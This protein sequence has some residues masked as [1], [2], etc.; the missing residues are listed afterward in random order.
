MRRSAIHRAVAM[1]WRTARRSALVDV[2]LALLET[3]NVTYSAMWKHVS[4]TEVTAASALRLAQRRNSLIRFVM[5]TVTI[6]AVA[7]TMETAVK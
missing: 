4:G 3:W 5:T 6:K 2:P 1:I 7:S